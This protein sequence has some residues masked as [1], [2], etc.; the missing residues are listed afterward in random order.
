M[1]SSLLEALSSP[2]MYDDAPRVA[3]HETHASWVFVAGPRAYKVKKPV[4]LGFLDY[5][6]L[7]RRHAACREEVRVNREL[8]PDIYLGVRAIVDTESGLRLTDEDTPGA[9]E[10]AVEMRAFDEADTLEGLLASGALTREQVRR[11]AR[12]LA[13]FHLA[14]SAADGGRVADVLDTWRRN[15][16][17]LARAS[18][19]RGWNVEPL[20]AFGE[21]FTSA[22]G[23]EIERRRLAGRVRDGHGDLR[24]E[25]VLAVPAVRVVDR[26]EFDPALRRVDVACDLAFLAMDLEAHG[27]RWAAQ[28]LLSAYRDAGASPGSEALRSFYAAHWSLVRTKVALIGAAEHA[29]EP[30]AAHLSQAHA[31]WRLSER[32]CWRARQP[33]ALFICGPAATGKSTLATELSRRCGMPVVRSDVLRKRLAGLA[34]TERARPEHYT[35]DFTRA[36]YGL[37]ADEA[38][39]RLREHEGVIVDATCRTRAERTRL[40]HRVQ[41]PWLTSLFIRCEAPLEVSSRWAAQRVRRPERTSDAT[42]E[43]VAAQFRCFEPLDELPARSVLA[44]NTQRSLDA[45]VAAVTR[46]VD[47]LLLESAPAPDAHFVTRTGL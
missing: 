14:A 43:I 8:A 27:A 4:A 31:L 45:Q 42:P 41:R 12:R 33:V 5:S 32:L 47:R 16:R 39:A 1:T 36:T 34:P 30:C 26:V 22:H 28:E 20:I 21:A 38:R 7:S 23:Q 24:C 2:A 13:A 40:R 9:L 15:V 19:G 18:A 17:E 25:H 37:L 11:V 35:E 46:A 29:G 44:L 3:V 6:T 10:Y